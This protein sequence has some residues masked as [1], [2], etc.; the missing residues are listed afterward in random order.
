[1]VALYDTAWYEQNLNYLRD[2][3]IFQNTCSRSEKVTVLGMHTLKLDSITAALKRVY[4][5]LQ[6]L[7]KTIK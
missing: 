2:F 6:V 5:T 7:I 1:M 4:T 3:L